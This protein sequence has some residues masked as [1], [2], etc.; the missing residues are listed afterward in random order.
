M[1]AHRKR[2]RTLPLGTRLACAALATPAAMVALPAVAL[3]SEAK[4]AE[5]AA[6][7][8]I[9]GPPALYSIQW[10]L[11]LALLAITVLFVVGSLAPEM[12]KRASAS[13]A[14]AILILSVLQI[15]LVFAIL[16][17]N[18]LGTEYK[19]PA[20]P[21]YARHVILILTGILLSID[22]LMARRKRP[23]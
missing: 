14:K 17:V 20:L 5:G 23:Y 22:G 19:E 15:L 16:I 6:E 8:G 9:L 13:R 1:I 21:G 12:R 4:T 10:A 11:L 18:F 3:A 2:N 7:S